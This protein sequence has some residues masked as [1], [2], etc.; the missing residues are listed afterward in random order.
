M[1]IK[2]PKLAPITMKIS[3]NPIFTPAVWVVDARGGLRLASE[4]EKEPE[5]YWAQNC[6]QSAANRP[7][8]ARQNGQKRSRHPSRSVKGV[9]ADISRGG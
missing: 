4:A 2:I 8:S 9:F 6:A 5:F 1:M 7:S 3:S